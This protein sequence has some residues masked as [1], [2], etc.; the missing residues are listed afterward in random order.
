MTSYSRDELSRMQTSSKLVLYRSLNHTA[1]SGLALHLDSLNTNGKRIKVEAR[2]GHLY[3][4]MTLAT[5]L[6]WPTH[7]AT[8]WLCGSAAERIETTQ[9]FLQEC[10]VL[11]PCRLRFREQISLAAVGTGRPAMAALEQFDA[12]GIEQINLILDNVH[13]TLRLMTSC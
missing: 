13:L 8:C 3:L 7:K 2:L 1:T 9:H 4:M 5:L 10:S 11:L 6:G 12:G